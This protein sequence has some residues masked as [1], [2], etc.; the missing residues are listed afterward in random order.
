MKVAVLFSGGKDSTYA[1]Y[2]AKQSGHDLQCLVTAN[3]Y[4]AESKLLHHPN[5]RLTSLQAKSMGLEHL[6]VDTDS[7]NE[8]D[9]LAS[10]LKKAVSKYDIK[11][12]VHGGIASIFQQKQFEAACRFVFRPSSM[13]RQDMLLFQ[14]FPYIHPIRTWTSL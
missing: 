8:L 9:S 4:S 3:P 1:A 12:V 5:I 7:E 6:T 14:R 13:P 11:G 2:L 10:L